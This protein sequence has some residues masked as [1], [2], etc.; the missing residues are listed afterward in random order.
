MKHI[1]LTFLLFYC[2]ATIPALAQTKAK[3]ASAQGTETLTNQSIIDLSSAGLDKDL[4]IS[5]IQTAQTSFDLSTNGLIALKKSKVDNDIIKAMMNK[6]NGVPIDKASP[7]SGTKPAQEKTEVA[8]FPPFTSVAPAN[9]KDC[10]IVEGKKKDGTK[11]IFAQANTKLG[12]LM[13]CRDK[14]KLTIVYGTKQLLFAIIQDTNNLATL[15]IDSAQFLFDNNSVLVLK[16]VDSYGK[17]PNRNNELKPQ[18]QDAHFTFFLEPGSKAEHTFT[19]SKLT[20][21]R[22]FGEREC[23]YGDA[24]NEK[25][26]NKLLTSFNCVP[27]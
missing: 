20:M 21:F 13:I 27:N 3:K 12:N 23:Q 14:G 4:I 10:L 6:S 18:L 9:S 19:T 17:V 25:Q 2:V 8:E 26:Q 1:L 24:L 11:I 5:K 16:T 15:K 22:I 7:G